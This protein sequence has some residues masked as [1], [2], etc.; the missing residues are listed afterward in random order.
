MTAVGIAGI[1]VFLVIVTLVVKPVGLYLYNVFDGGRT[2]LD[3]VLAPVERA[4]YK[5]GGV[6]PAKEMRWTEYLFALL[7]FNLAG[8]V[9]L[10]PVLRLQGALPLNPQHFS[11]VGAHVAWNTAVS[12]VTNTNWQ[13]Y[14]GESTLSYLSQMWLTVQQ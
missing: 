6:D 1:V 9:L 4:I 7:A 14:G 8:F 10:Y 11:G 13:A 5:V 2:W 3:P 12:F